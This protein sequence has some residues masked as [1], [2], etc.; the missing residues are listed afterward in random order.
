M[1]N[2]T[3][4]KDFCSVYEG[5]YQEGISPVG[6]FFSQGEKSVLGD[7]VG[8]WAGHKHNRRPY[9]GFMP[10]RAAHGKK[11]NLAVF[12]C[13]FEQFPNFPVH[14]YKKNLIPLTMRW[15]FSEGR[16]WKRKRSCSATGEV[17]MWMFIVCK[18]GH[19]NPLLFRYAAYS[20]IHRTASMSR[21]AFSWRN[22]RG[23]M[24]AGLPWLR[25]TGKSGNYSKG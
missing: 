19:S 20:P 3:P 23:I 25:W 2:S 11:G 18:S 14:R 12:L 1:A 4:G 7:G 16:G 8:C 24:T 5:I 21:T 10:R 17:P 22:I 13:F 15:N 9:I 6:C